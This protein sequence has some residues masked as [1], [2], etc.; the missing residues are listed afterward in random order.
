MATSP[1]N[2]DLL[3][4]TA[5]DYFTE[6]QVIVLENEEKPFLP[7]FEADGN[8]NRF[9]TATGIWSA[10]YDAKNRPTNFTMP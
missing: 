4:L 5:P 3:S 9:K 7:E 1:V 10:V 2:A 6:E 8:Q